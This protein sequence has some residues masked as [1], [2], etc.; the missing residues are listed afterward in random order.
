MGPSRA[1]IVEGVIGQLCD[2]RAVRLHDEGLEETGVS[3][4]GKGNHLTG[5]GRSVTAQSSLKHRSRWDWGV[6]RCDNRDD[7]RR[8]R[9]SLQSEGHES[10][11]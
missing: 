2:L 1:R 10:S 4:A 9:K 11:L 6:A 5:D 3:G 7:R 8:V